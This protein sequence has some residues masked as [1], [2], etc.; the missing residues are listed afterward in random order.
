M[1]LRATLWALDQAPVNDPTEKLI[2]I[3]MADWANDDGQGVWPS[4]ETISRRA[5]CDARTVQRKLRALETAGL[6]QK[7]TE[8]VDPRYFA[9]PTNRRPTI[10]RLRLDRTAPPRGDSVSPLGQPASTN[11]QV[12]RG[13]TQTPLIQPGVTGTAARGDATVSP[14]PS[15]DPTDHQTASQSGPALRVV[16]G[17]KGKKR[18]GFKNPETEVADEIVTAWWDTLGD[19]KPIESFMQIRTNV[20]KAIKA[21]HPR[22]AVAAA[23]T[24]THTDGYSITAGTLTRSLSASP[25]GSVG[26]SRYG[27]PS[28]ARCNADDSAYNAQSF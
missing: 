2:L 11:G 1:S 5:V 23:L 20:A 25:R 17:G 8:F 26:A 3:A 19:I 18:T 9:I 22:E 15:V 6:I 7:D 13:D 27:V 28:S 16:E 21:G 12:K 10:W 4:V 24:R 14:N